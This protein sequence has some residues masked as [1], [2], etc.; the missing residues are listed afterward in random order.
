V[1]TPASFR[2]QKEL[3]PRLM[4]ESLVAARPQQG[5]AA[6][7]L[8]SQE[9][10]RPFLALLIILVVLSVALT[11]YGLYDVAVVASQHRS[12]SGTSASIA[13]AGVILL[14]AAYTLDQLRRYFLRQIEREA[15]ATRAVRELRESDFED[16]DWQVI[17]REQKAREDFARNV[18]STFVVSQFSA[19]DVALFPETTWQL[20]P[21][22]NVLL[23]RNGFGKSL[24]LRS[25]V[26]LLQRDELS[27]DAL[28]STD[29]Q[30]GS[31]AELHV[32]Q[33]AASRVV[34]RTPARF[35]EAVGKIPVLAIPDSRFLDRTHSKFVP[36]DG[37]AID[38]LQNGSA[39]FLQQQP[40]GSVI[41]G[42][43]YE[44]CLD[45]WEGGRSFDQPVFQFYTDCV[46]RLTNCEFRFHEINR[47]G[48]AGFEINVLTDG[49]RQPLPIQAASQGTLSVL[50]MFGLI[51]SY[52]EAAANQR[53]DSSSGKTPAIVVIDEADAHLHPAWQQKFPT[54][55]KDMFPNVQFILSAHSP[56]FVAGCWRG[57]V[58]VL[59][60]DKSRADRPGFRVEQLDR[61]FVGATAADLYRDIF[62][63]EEMDETYLEYA[64]KAT[65]WSSL[66]DRLN[67][68]IVLR[69]KGELRRPEADELKKLSEESHRI[70]RAVGVKEERDRATQLQLRIDELESELLKVRAA[71][72]PAGKAL[73][74]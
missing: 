27:T 6:T 39:H 55:L 40:Y 69:E 13:M 52:I 31:Y 49:N 56:L 41:Q 21:R 74:Q 9:L 47:V 36:E 1:S 44:I 64:T 3:K 18:E 28:F 25:I 23:G 71:G 11:A 37:S 59:R 42:L 57:E 30:S 48:R 61:D 24:L 67:E 22:V 12:L 62:E 2:P 73:A 70:H 14:V 66:G 15:E 50:A 45:Y 46:R 53:G 54:A 8:T 10:R 16:L 60:R 20:E 68:L 32:L 72:D 43:L 17:L 5:A 63:I 58:A 65:Q 35:S 29:L 38:L 4:A 33:N 26:G 51:R 19:K 7:L 34:R